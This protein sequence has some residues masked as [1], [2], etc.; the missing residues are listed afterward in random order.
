MWLIKTFE[1]YYDLEQWTDEWIKTHSVDSWERIFLPN[2]YYAVAYFELLGLSNLIKTIR[3]D[4]ER[5]KNNQQI[6][7]AYHDL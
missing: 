7:D 1:S 5:Q 3:E 4:I 6:I 2:V